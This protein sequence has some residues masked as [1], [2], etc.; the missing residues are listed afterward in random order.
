MRIE[1]AYDDHGLVPAI[2]QDASTGH[3]LMLGYVNAVSLDATYRTGK[4][5]FWSRSRDELWQKG[6][7]SGNSMS[8]VDISIDCDADAVL[9]RVD[10]AG[11][12]CHVGSTSCF[13][14]ARYRET[15]PQ[16]GDIV[17]SLWRT[18]SSRAEQRPRIDRLWRRS[19]P[20]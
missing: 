17:S 1:P 14:T 2:V 11:P 5:H 8:V 16:I 9:V 19:P 7:T 18:I 13:A 4:M 20:S 10:P 12:A 6:E 3:V 15:T